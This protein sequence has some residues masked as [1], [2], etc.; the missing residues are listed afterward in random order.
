MPDEDY[1][2][3]RQHL[4]QPDVADQPFL[5]YVLRH[6][7]STI[8]HNCDGMY[9]DLV[10]G[11]SYVTYSVNGDPAQIGLMRH[12]PRSELECDVIPVCSNLGAALIGMRVGQ[13]APLLREDGTIASLRVLKVTSA[14]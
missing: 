4:N 10:T 8:T 7:L 12:R 6:K 11:A 13:R 2:Q 1:R 9:E 14:A 5:R 3:L